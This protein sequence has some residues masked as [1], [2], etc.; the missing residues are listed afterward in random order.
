MAAEKSLPLRSNLNLPLG[1]WMP[2]LEE[3]ITNKP[4]NPATKCYVCPRV[5]R[6]TPLLLGLGKKEFSG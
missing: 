2:A 6:P 4:I 5:T 1:V 3:N